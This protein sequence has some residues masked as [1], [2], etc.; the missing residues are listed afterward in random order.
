M[1]TVSATK[2]RRFSVFPT[3]PRRRYSNASSTA[4]EG[5]VEREVSSA[6]GSAS[7]PQRS[8][9][10][11]ARARAPGGGRR[12]GGQPRVGLRLAAEEEQ[13]YARA[14]AAPAQI[15]QALGPSPAPA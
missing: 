2:R 7:P 12:G 6:S 15:F 10:M 9:G 14:R 5:A 4:P 13:G 3:P 1:S 8:Q 11:P